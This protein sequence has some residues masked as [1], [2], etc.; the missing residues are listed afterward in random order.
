M[1]VKDMTVEE[2]WFRENTQG[3][4]RVSPREGVSRKE[5]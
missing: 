5:A 3:Q 4:S 1:I 2:I